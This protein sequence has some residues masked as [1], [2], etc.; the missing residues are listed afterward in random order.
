MATEELLEKYIE[1]RCDTSY[2]RDILGGRVHDTG[3]VHLMHALSRDHVH[4]G[5]QAFASA[6][7]PARLS[8]HTSAP[9]LCHYLAGF[10]ETA[11]RSLSP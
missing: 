11:G 8:S 7:V 5:W 9:S 10:K 1:N 2:A 3:H 6:Q 4:L